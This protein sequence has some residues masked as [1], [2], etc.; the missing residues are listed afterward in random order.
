MYVYIYIYADTRSLF[1]GLINAA[2]VN[3]QRTTD[4]TSKVLSFAKL[5]VVSE[6]T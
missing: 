5:L 1:S 6:Q 3:E 2:Q 4:V